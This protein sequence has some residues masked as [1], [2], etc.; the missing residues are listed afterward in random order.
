MGEVRA[1]VI[2]SNPLNPDSPELELDACIDTGAV[3]V[4]IGHDIADRLG[5]IDMGKAVVT[6]ADDTT[7]E[8]PRAGP[9]KLTIGDRSDYFSCLVGA[10]GCEPLIGQL[11]LEALDLIVDCQHQTLRPRPSSP[12]YPSYKMK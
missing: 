8:M 2:A 10:P 12:A 9:L 5:L 1:Q 4:L 6:L 11:V 3:V 7:K